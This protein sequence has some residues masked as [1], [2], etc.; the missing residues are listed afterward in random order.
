[1]LTRF[2]NNS[3]D[4]VSAVCGDMN[5]FGRVYVGG[6]GSGWRYGDYADLAIAT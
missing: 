3:L 2:P 1:L 6:P 5:I 4:N